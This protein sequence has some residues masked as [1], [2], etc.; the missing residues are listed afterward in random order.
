[1][2]RKVNVRLLMRRAFLFFC[3]LVVLA[4]PVHAA[5]VNFEV[6]N[7]VQ[8]SKLRE[9]KAWTALYYLDVDWDSNNYDVLEQV[10]I[11]EICS[12]ANLNVVVIQDMEE[13]P[14]FLYYIDENHTK[15]LLEEL[16]EVNMADYLTLRDFISYGKEYYPAERYQ[17]NVYDHGG[18]WKGACIDKTSGGDIMTMDEFQKALGESGGVDLLCFVACCVMGSLESVYELHE[19][20]DVYVGSEDLGYMAWWDGML[21]DM[22]FLLNNHSEFSTIK[23]GQEIIRLIS[24]NHNMYERKVTMSAIQ[25]DKVQPL[26]DAVDTLSKHLLRKWLRS[27]YWKVREAHENT[28]LL[29]DYQEWA[30]I[31]ELYDLKGFVQNLEQDQYANEVLTAFD[32]AVIAECHGAEKEGTYGLSIFFPD[33]PSEY[34]LAQIYKDKDEGLDFPRDT[35]WN[36]FLFIFILTNLIFRW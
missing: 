5:V 11:D 2:S 24:D 29:A 23:I 22:C 3:I 36:E 13:E 32:E 6:P 19:L 31:F 30:E 1:M 9:P 20:C 34:D 4:L 14:A 26:V 12:G 8:I 25:T 17:L 35:F 28:F 33:T 21:G 10:F 15:I 7:D 16:G 27:S 18:A